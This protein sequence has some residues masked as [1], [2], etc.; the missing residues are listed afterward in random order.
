[1]DSF[2]TKYGSDK[3]AI[4]SSMTSSSVTSLK[5][6]WGVLTFETTNRHAVVL[7]RRCPTP[8]PLDTSDV[9]EIMLERGSSKRQV[10]ECQF[11]IH[12]RATWTQ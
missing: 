12:T 6:C 11:A 8:H 3:N 9:I 4:A 5:S 10:I 2:Y 1:M 7:H